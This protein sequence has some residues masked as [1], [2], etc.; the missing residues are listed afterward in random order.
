MG[1]Y[2]LLGGDPKDSTSHVSQAF[3]VGSC[4]CS[5]RFFSGYSGFPS[6]QKPSLPNSNSIWRVCPHCKGHLIISSCNLICAMQICKRIYLFISFRKPRLER[7]A[8]IWPAS[9]LVCP[10]CKLTLRYLRMTEN[11]YLITTC[12]TCFSHLQELSFP[13]HSQL[14]Q[15]M[16]IKA[17]T[18]TT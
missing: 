2:Y 9:I 16:I 4:P 1:F 13:S 18:D 15:M 3:V 14:L 5:K 10:Q 6:P 12:L 11:L 8:Y 17:K 7:P